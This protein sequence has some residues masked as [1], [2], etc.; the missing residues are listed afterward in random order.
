M[1][2]GSQAP[3]RIRTLPSWL[4]GRAAARGHRL[5]A[6]ALAQAGVR[7]MHHAVLCAVA[8]REPVSQAD[9]GRSLRVDPKDMVAILNDLHDDGLIVRA[10]DPHDRRKNAVSISA[11]GTQLLRRTQTLG[12]EANDQL[13][14]ALTAT[15]REH[16]VRLLERIVSP[17]EACQ[18]SDGT[19]GG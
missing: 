3:V 12:D 6:E 16:L 18:T 19:P 10:P 7:M 5:V 11:D 8:E 2:D 13:T 14:A 17:V 15:E 1:T 9:L 4:L